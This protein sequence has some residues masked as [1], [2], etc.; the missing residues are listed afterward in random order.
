ML[1]Y[2]I[3]IYRDFSGDGQFLSLN[4]TANVYIS[5][6]SHLWKNRILINPVINY[7]INMYSRV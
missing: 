4:S 7:V 5:T 2:I 3:I 1:I 6:I